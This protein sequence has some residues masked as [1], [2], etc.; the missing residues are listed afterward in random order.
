MLRYLNCKKQQL[1]CGLN[2][3][4]SMD[5]EIRIQS[6]TWHWQKVIIKKSLKT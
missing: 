2:S 3:R 6:H 5:L 4:N 1:D